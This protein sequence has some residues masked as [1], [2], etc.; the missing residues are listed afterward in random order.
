MRP[1]K[2]MQRMRDNVCESLYE[3]KK[4]RSQSVVKC[5]CS[6]CVRGFIKPKSQSDQDTGFKIKHLFN[7]EHAYS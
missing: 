1:Q 7:D 2:R 3:A 6:S 5:S 4:F